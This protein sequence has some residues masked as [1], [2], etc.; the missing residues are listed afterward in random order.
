MTEQG[1]FSARLDICTL[2]KFDWKNGMWNG[3]PIKEK[4]VLVVDDD[5]S[6]RESLS[7]LLDVEGYSVLAAENGQ[8]ALDIL[9]KAAHFPCLILLDLAMP[10]MDGR[11]FLKFRAKDPMLRQI[12][13]VV[14][15]GDPPR[16]EQLSGIEAYLQKPVR[17]DRLIATV[18]L[19]ARS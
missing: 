5:R 10:I 15:S 11:G 6:V 14:V 7:G 4:L 16:G 8:T 17:F 19:A 12:P 2:L 3:K 9:E 13:V 1:E 18:D